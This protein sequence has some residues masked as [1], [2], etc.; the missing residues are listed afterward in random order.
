MATKIGRGDYV[1]DIYACAKLHFDPIRGF[2]PH[3]CEVAY[4]MFTRVVFWGPSNSL[5]P[6]PL[7]RSSKDVVSRKDV[8]F[9]V[10]KTIFLHFDL[11]SAKMQI[12]VDIRRNL[13][14]LKTG[15]NMG[16]FVSK[17]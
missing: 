4:Q 13:F 1:P 3:I 6:R 11:I 2:G 7:R 12:L 17:Q 10:L 9:G 15:F 14:R 16:D 5:S 8:P